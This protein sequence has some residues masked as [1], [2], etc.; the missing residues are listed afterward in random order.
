MFP[1]LTPMAVDPIHPFPLISTLSLSLAVKLFIRN[2]KK[3]LFARIKIP[4]FYSA[5]IPLSSSHSKQKFFLSSTDLIAKHLQSLFPKMK[6]A[7]ALPFRITR[8]I[9]IE[10]ESEEEGAEDLLEFVEEEIRRRKFAEIVRLEHGPQPDPWLLD[11]LKKELKI[12][13]QDIYELP[14]P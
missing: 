2:N 6:I 11:F 12:K 1:I 13:N 10:N 8:N 4:D 5:W 14:L 3:P 9:D 7:A